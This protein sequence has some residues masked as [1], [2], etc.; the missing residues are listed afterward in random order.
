MDEVNLTAQE[1]AEL[2]LLQKTQAFA[3]GSILIREGDLVSH[4]YTVVQ[5]CVRTYSILN[6]EEVTVDFY[7]E[8][9]AIV[10]NVTTSQNRSPYFVVC[11][12]NCVLQVVDEAMEKAVFERLPRLKDVCRQQ[13]ERLLV[14][15]QSEFAKFKSYSPEQRYQH[16]LQVRPGLLER[17][18][19]Y[20][21]ASYL[22]IKPESL[23]RLRK[24][25]AQRSN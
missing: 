12:E 16:L 5:G 10:S 22:G 21:I 6:D 24:R 13:S 3:K 7:T 15:A 23:S 2:K 25:M 17:V 1:L 20:Q 14:E 4:Y 11:E 8:G 18:P 9:Q 19:Q